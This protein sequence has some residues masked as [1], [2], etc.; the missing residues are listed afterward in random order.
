MTQ[1]VA[2]WMKDNPIVLF[3]LILFTM[4]LVYLGSKTVEWH[5]KANQVKPP[6]I[7]FLKGILGDHSINY[8]HIIP[9]SKSETVAKYRIMSYWIMALMYLMVVVLLVLGISYKLAAANP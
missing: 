1:I 4:V 5:Y 2:E 3:W 6:R 9:R 7:S 8:V